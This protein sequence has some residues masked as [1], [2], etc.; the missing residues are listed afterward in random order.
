MVARRI[1]T[2]LPHLKDAEIDTLSQIYEH[3]GLRPADCGVFRMV[4]RPFRAPHHTISQIA[5]VGNAKRPGEFKLATYGVLFLDELPEFSTKAIGAL[6]NHL[7]QEKNHGIMIVA[8]SNPCP[9]GWNGYSE[10]RH[11]TCSHRLV[12]AYRQ[13]V[14]T[15]CKMLDIVDF[16]NIP[17]V[18]LTQIKETEPG[19]D[20]ATI[21]ARLM[22][23]MS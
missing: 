19:E 3:A 8:S 2:I 12:T 22:E 14:Q 16:V 17:S 7:A 4:T 10:V 15:F 23:A 21:R 6:G 1:P 18:T 5:L 13:R 20:S 11:C 9:C